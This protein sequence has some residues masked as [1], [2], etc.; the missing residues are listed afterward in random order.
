[1]IFYQKIFYWSH[2]LILRWLRTWLHNL[3]PFILSFYKINV[4]CRF[5]KIIQVSLILRVWLGVFI[6]FLF[7]NCSWLFIIVYFFLIKLQKIVLKKN[8]VITLFKVTKLKG[9]KILLFTHTHCIVDYNVLLFS[10][11][12]GYL[13]W[14]FFQ[15]FFI[16]FII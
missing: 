12:L 13:L 9:V 6:F 8:H 5:G 7:L 4:V 3:F 14:Y 2:L 1:M 15:N 10:F 11:V 16:G